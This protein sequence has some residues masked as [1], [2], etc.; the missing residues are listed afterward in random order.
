VQQTRED[1][2]HAPAAG[3]AAPSLAA[4]KEEAEVEQQEHTPHDDATCRTGED[5]DGS[6]DGMAKDDARRCRGKRRALA[7]DEVPEGFTCARCF[8]SKV[9]H[10]HT[11]THIP[12]PGT[13]RGSSMPRPVETQA[14][15]APLAPSSI[16]SFPCCRILNALC[17]PSCPAGQVRSSAALRQVSG[18]L[19]AMLSGCLTALPL[20]H[21]PPSPVS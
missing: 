5:G 21:L 19:R 13:H 2:V 20:A 7:S 18:A 15:V 12:W 6:Q 1:P 17:L 11:Y 3:D 10:T 8:R 16:P 9:S 4:V 14:V